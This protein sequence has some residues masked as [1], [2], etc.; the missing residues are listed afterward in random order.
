MCQERIGAP[1]YLAG[2]WKNGQALGGADNNTACATGANHKHLCPNNN[3]ATR[4]RS[5]GA[6]SRSSPRVPSTGTWRR[7]A[8]CP[9]WLGG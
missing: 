7:T 8:A 6:R 3:P 4:P 9:H 2:G 1:G 5:P